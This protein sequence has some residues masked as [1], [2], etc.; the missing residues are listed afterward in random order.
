MLS[1]CPG[2]SRYHSNCSLAL[3]LSVG[4]LVLTHPARGRPGASWPHPLIGCGQR[5]ADAPPPSVR[6]SAAPRAERR[7]SLPAGL[8]GARSGSLPRGLADQPEGWLA[9]TVAILSPGNHL[10]LPSRPP[11]AIRL[12]AR[13]KN[14]RAAGNPVRSHMGTLYLGELRSL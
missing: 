13:L 10:P 1:V 9:G 5:R 7:G 2:S 11:R 14:G 8:A 6:C 3:A 4:E 12:S